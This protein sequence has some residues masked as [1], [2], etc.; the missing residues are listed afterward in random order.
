M[1]AGVCNKHGP[2]GARGALVGMWTLL[3]SC[4][5]LLLPSLP[6]VPYKVFSLSFFRK[7]ASKLRSRQEPPQ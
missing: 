3:I 4:P 7:V 1:W 5:V 2:P 6:V